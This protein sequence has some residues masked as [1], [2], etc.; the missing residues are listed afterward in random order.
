MA[1]WFNM[2]KDQMTQ[3]GDDFD[4]RVCTL[5]EAGLLVAFDDGFG[6][7][8]GAAFTAWGENY[9]YFPLEYDGAESVGHAP[10][11]PRNTAMEHQ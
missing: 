6:A 8:N 11:N 1:T 7:I 5:D 9:V 2:L 3:L 10:R 4:K